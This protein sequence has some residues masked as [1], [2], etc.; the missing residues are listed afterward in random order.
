MITE[1]RKLRDKVKCTWDYCLCERYNKI[2][3]AIKL[4]NNRM[5]VLEGKLEIAKGKLEIAEDKNEMLHSRC[6]HLKDLLEE[7]SD[8]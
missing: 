1:L 8:E 3:D 4:Q 5:E 6:M 2:I 7:R